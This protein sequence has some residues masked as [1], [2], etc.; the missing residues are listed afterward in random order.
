MVEVNLH[1]VRHKQIQVSITIEVEKRAASSKAVS[2]VEQ[3]SLDRNVGK[4]SVPVV[5][6][7]TVMAVVGENR[8]SQ[9][10]LL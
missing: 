2:R 10:S 4:C 3:A 6:V 8:S 9:P 7:E 5:P 1:I